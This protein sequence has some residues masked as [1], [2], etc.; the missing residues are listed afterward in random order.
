MDCAN[1]AYVAES[2]EKGGTWAGVIDGLRKKRKIFVRQAGINEKNANSLLIQKGAIPVDAEGEEIVERRYVDAPLGEL[3]LV[4]EPGQRY[5]DGDSLEKKILSLFNGAPLT[6]NE[7][8]DK[9]KL[10]LTSQKLTGVL[11][12]LPQIEVIETKHPHKFQLKDKFDPPQKSLF[13]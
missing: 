5:Q 4:N 7:I 2:S 8:L 1:D 9:L 11:K 13:D 12:R 10:E 6:A 3:M